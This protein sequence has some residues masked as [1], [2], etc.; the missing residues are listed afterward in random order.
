MGIT[1][2][3]TAGT[4]ALTTLTAVKDALQLTVDTYDA[5][6]ERM[7]RAASDAISQYAGRVYA[8]QDYVE[9]LPGNDWPH[10]ALTNT[11][12]VGTPTIL[13]DSEPVT[14]FV[15]QDADAGMLYREVGWVREAWVGWA[16]ERYT[17]PSTEQHNVNVT[18]TAGYLL[19]GEDD[20]NLP[21]DVEEAC[22]ITVCAWHRKEQRGGGD[23]QSRKVGDLAITYADQT[24]AQGVVTAAGL[25]PDARALISRRVL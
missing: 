25:P 13:I 1:V 7:I 4:T 18:Y 20:R 15:V 11:P 9:T 24:N 2:T 16:V 10:L 8:R 19:P 21:Y 3:T 5:L 12:I 6:L 14:D 17:L 22:I 23:V